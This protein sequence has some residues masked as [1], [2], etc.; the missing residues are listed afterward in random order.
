[1]KNNKEETG[2]VLIYTGNGKGK[3]TAALGAALRAVGHGYKVAV[4]QFIK[5]PGFTYGEEYAAQHYIP[6]LEII[7]KGKGYYKIRGDSVPEEVH[8]KAARDGLRLAEEKIV[9]GN[10]HIVILDEINIAVDKGLLSVE[11]V[12]GI[13]DNKPTKV[14]IILTGRNAHPALIE[15]ADV[16]TEMKEIKHPF[17]KG[18]K[19]QSGIDY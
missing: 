14:H 9:S 2:L 4:I 7:K 5:G 18:I 13:L 19:A 12:L 1:M 17:Q 6:N 16:V 15:R 3:T 8:R 10:Y 11:E